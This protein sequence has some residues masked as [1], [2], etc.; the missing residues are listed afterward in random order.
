VDVKPGGLGSTLALVA[1]PAGD[2]DE[3]RRSQVRLRAQ[4]R[5]ELVAVGARHADVA[6]DDVGSELFGGANAGRAAV[7]GPGLM[8]GVLEQRGERVGDV[9]VV[10][11]DEEAQ[12]PAPI[13]RTRSAPTTARCLRRRG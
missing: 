7:F 12:A 9:G 1:A 4:L 5:S 10:V 13:G 8:A 6:E 11:D 2:G 3:K